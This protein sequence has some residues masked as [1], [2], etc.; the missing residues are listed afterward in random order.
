MKQAIGESIYLTDV[1]EA[2]ILAAIENP[3]LVEE[4][5]RRWGYGME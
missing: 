3:D 5:L 2:A 1:K 4:I